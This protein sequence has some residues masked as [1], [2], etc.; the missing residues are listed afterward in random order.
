M[1]GVVVSGDQAIDGAEVTLESEDGRTRI[2]TPPSDGNGFFGR[3]GVP[4]GIYRVVVA[5][6]GD[7]VY[8]SRCTVAVTAGSVASVALRI[9]PGVPA[10]ATC[11]T[12]APATATR[13]P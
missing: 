8:R 7:G 11:S 13:R 5:P 12:A 4:P 2:A 10:V 6:P 9:D 3:V 1:K